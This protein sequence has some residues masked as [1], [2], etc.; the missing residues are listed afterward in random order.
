L[1]RSATR[2]FALARAI[3]GGPLVSLAVPI[4]VLAAFQ[5]VCTRWA[6]RKPGSARAT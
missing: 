1:K 3:E 6:D 4:G 2:G 5:R